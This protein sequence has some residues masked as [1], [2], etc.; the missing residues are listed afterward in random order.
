MSATFNL[1]LDTQAP[2]NPSLLINGGAAA[3]GEQICWITLASTDYLTG[4]RDLAMMKV[5][6]DV[7][8]LADPS[9]TPMEADAAWVPFEEQVPV[10]LSAGTGRK[11]LYARLRDDVGNISLTFSDFIDYDTTV[12]VVTI[13][14]AVDRSRISK[15]S[16][17]DAA[18]F[19]WEASVPILAY[20]VRVVP[21]TGSPYQAGVPLGVVNGS[22]NTD[23]S[24]SIEANTPTITTIKGAD[25]E[26]ASPGN[27]TKVIKVFVQN[28][29]GVWSA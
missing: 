13:T 16:P 19:T 4:A 21:S 28:L 15:V 27:T 2:A 6:G 8:L 3:T 7:D 14:T 1:T 20:Q 26:T 18:T 29:T 9:F 25:L 22:V 11:Y 17:Y 23:G 10:M 5:W 12:P 24:G